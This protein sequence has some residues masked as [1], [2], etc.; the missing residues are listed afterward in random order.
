MRLSNR[1]RMFSSQQLQQHTTTRQHFL[2]Q[3]QMPPCRHVIVNQNNMNIGN[4]HVVTIDCCLIHASKQR[5]EQSPQV[6][7][8]TNKNASFR[9]LRS[10]PK[11]RPPTLSP[12]NTPCRTPSSSASILMH[13]SNAPLSQCASLSLQNASFVWHL[14]R[15]PHDYSGCSLDRQNHSH[16]I[17]IIFTF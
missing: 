3:V 2:H 6:V 5:Q 9:S 14:R 7:W 16:T 15:L 4:S 12:C 10:Q 11:S 17:V 8:P 13:L 1:V